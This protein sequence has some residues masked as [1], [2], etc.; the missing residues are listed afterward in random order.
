MHVYFLRY[1]ERKSSYKKR[2]NYGLVIFDL[3]I[4]QILVFILV[5][6]AFPKFWEG[7]VSSFLENIYLVSETYKSNENSIF[8]NDFLRYLRS[9]L[10]Y[11]C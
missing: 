1:Y 4:K 10:I 7:K 9:I 6:Y 11:F 8:L 2:D 3:V 5:F